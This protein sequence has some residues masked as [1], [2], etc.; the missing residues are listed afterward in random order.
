MGGNIRCGVP[1]ELAE[2]HIAAAPRAGNRQRARWPIRVPE[3]VPLRALG[4]V[5]TAADPW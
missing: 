4:R 5:V 3:A 2:V 1:D